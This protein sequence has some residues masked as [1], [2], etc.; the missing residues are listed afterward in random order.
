MGDL[1]RPRFERRDHA[2]EAQRSQ[3]AFEFSD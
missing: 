2:G 1:Q 3:R